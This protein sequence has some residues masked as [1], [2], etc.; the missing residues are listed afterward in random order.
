M[1]SLEASRARERLVAAMLPRTT[2][3][4]RTMRSSVRVKPAF[5]GRR[6]MEGILPP[7]DEGDASR[8]GRHHD[9]AALE[10]A[11]ERFLER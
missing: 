6:V 7:L 9:R 10:T 4:P 3:M 1:D 11:E 5:R 2:R 8:F